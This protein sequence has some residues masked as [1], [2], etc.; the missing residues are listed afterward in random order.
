MGITLFIR[1]ENRFPEPI[2]RPALFADPAFTIPNVMNVLANLAGFAILLLTPYYLG[3]HTGHVGRR[4]RRDAGAGLRR[5]HGRCA[6]GGPPGAA[7]RPAADRLCR[8]RGHGLGLLPL[9]L[10]ERRHAVLALVALLLVEGV[11]T[12]CSSSPT[13][14]S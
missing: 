3:E 13:P 7:H 8:H 9:G 14:I 6:A 12:A 10:T 5:R 2:I 1:R 11:A 4:H